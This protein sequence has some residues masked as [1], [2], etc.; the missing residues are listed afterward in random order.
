[1]SM[2]TYC[3]ICK[4]PADTRCTLC[5]QPV[6]KQHQSIGPTWVDHG[7]GPFSDTIVYASRCRLCLSRLAGQWGMPE[8]I[9]PGEY[10][11]PAQDEEVKP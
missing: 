3:H 2:T 7:T 9:G 6:C 5:R 4:Q 1:M 10:R 11:W 8:R